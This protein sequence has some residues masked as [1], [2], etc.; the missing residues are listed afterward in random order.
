MAASEKPLH[1]YEQ[2]MLLVSMLFDAKN[3]NEILSL[4]PERQSMRM[5]KANEKFLKM[6]RNDRMTEIVLELRRMLL[7]DEHRIDWIHQSWI[8]DALASEPAYLRPFIDDALKHGAQK[9]H[10]EIMREFIPPPVIFNMFVDQLSAT[11]QK[12][13]IYDPVLMRLQS[14]KDEAQDE[15]FATLGRWSIS[16]LQE[17]IAKERLSRFVAERGIKDPLLPLDDIKAKPWQHAPL[18]SR[19]V[20]ELARFRLSPALSCAQFA[21]LLTT[22]L[23]LLPFKHDWQRSITL[24]FYHQFGLIVESIIKRHTHFVV[25]KSAHQQLARLIIAA[26][27]KVQS[28]TL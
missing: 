26:L 8:D 1:P 11:R 14:L 6:P 10:D 9:K 19:F 4:L 3:I 17:V 25:D 12:T 27:D 28:P 21:G 15:V 16:C 22:A 20:R 2:S 5:H 24:G 18:R 13:A 7:I 23:Y